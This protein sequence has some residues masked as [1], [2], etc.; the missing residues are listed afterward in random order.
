MTFRRRAEFGLLWGGCDCAAKAVQFGNSQKMAV[1]IHPRNLRGPWVAGYS[2]DVHTTS[3][4]MIG[5]N[6]YGHPVFDTVRSPLGELLYRLK[7]KG[8]ETVLPEI[9]DTVARFLRGWGMRL[10]GIVPVPP[11]NIARKRQ[12]VIAVATALSDTL[13]V[14]LCEACI[15]KVKSTA[16]L[17]DVFDFAQRTEVLNGAFAVSVA[18]TRGKRLL[19]LDDLYRSGA[20]VSAIA[21]LLAGEGAAAAVYLL[22]LTQTRKLS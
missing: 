7:N 21:Q 6:A 19:L 3:S 20:T 11:S 8:D 18:K 13:R 10:D 1:T 4:T 17:K 12:P 16:Q 2:L 14:P 5:S 22:T 9:V 15:K